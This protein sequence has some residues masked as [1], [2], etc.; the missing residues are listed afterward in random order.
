MN[1]AVPDVKS[2]FGRAAEIDSPA[3]RA[4]YLDEACGGD[5]ELR[6]RSKNCWRRPT[7]PANSCSV[8]PWPRFTLPPTSSWL[9]RAPARSSG[10]TS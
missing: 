5:A 6:R 3:E 4:A 2:I 9:R 1:S 10:R 8:R 7:T